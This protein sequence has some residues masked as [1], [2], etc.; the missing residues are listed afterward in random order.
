MSC[1]YFVHVCNAPPLHLLFLTLGY[2]A[3][4]SNFLFASDVF[5]NVP[6]FVYSPMSLVCVMSGQ[7]WDK[8]LNYVPTACRQRSCTDTTACVLCTSILCTRGRQSFS[9]CGPVSTWDFFADRPSLKYWV[10]NLCK[11]ITTRESSCHWFSERSG[12]ALPQWDAPTCRDY[13]SQWQP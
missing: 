4:F 13:C 9:H 5:R 2:I 6:H 1:D 11:F 3:C 12:L 10:F 8:K 7:R